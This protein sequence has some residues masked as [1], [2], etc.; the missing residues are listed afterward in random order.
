MQP[1][2]RLFLSRRDPQKREMYG[3]DYKVFGGQSFCQFSLSIIFI[4]IHMQY[5]D[6]WS[7]QNDKRFKRRQLKNE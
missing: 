2:R 3:V 4:Q 1:I 5:N 6:H 7:K